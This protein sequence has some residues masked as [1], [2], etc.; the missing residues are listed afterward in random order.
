MSIYSAV[1]RQRFL[2][3]AALAIFWCVLSPVATGQHAHSNHAAGSVD[4]TVS[5]RDGETALIE[6]F[7][8][9]LDDPPPG[10]GVARALAFVGDAY[11]HITYGRPLKRGRII[12]G[13]LVGFDQLWPVGAHYASEI[14]ITGPLNMGGTDL[15]AGAYSVFA[16]PGTSAWTLHFNNVLGMHQADLYDP[17]HDVLVVEVPVETLDEVT[18]ALTIDFE[19][20]DDGVDLRITWDQT[21]VRLPVRSP[22]HSR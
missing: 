3:L 7:R 11:I 14:F 20:V 1:L 18:E 16:T 12:F 13:G 22:Q 17:A 5:D 19:N 9:D 2:G 15:P 8:L 6:G 4:T 21:R 10:S